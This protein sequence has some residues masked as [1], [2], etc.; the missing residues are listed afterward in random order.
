MQGNRTATFPTQR[1][2]LLPTPLL[3]PQLAAASFGEVLLQAIGGVY[4]NE[5][6][7]FLGGGNPFAVG[8]HKL[9]RTGANVRSQLQVRLP[10]LLFTPST[11][12]GAQ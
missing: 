9:K 2:S 1:I 4:R 11:V 7:T 3:P 12:S 5:A 8:I 10:P 6:A